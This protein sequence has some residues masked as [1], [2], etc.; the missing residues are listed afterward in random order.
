MVPYFLD[1]VI[2]FHIQLAGAPDGFNLNASTTIAADSIGT[3]PEPNLVL[4]PKNMKSRVPKDADETAMIIAVTFNPDDSIAYYVQLKSGKVFKLF[5]DKFVH[6]IDQIDPNAPPSLSILTSHSLSRL[7]RDAWDHNEEANPLTGAAMTTAKRAIEGIP[8]YMAT[9]SE[10]ACQSITCL[11][12]GGKPAMFNP[13]LKSCYCQTLAP[14]EKTFSKRNNPSQLDTIKSSA[15]REEDKSLMRSFFPIAR[16]SSETCRLM[17]SCQ[18]ESEPYFD[19]GSS[20]CLCVVYRSGVKEPVIASDTNILPRME[21][22]ASQQEED[23][24]ANSDEAALHERA[25]DSIDSQTFCSVEFARNNCYGKRVGRWNKDH[26][27]CVC[28]HL[29]DLEFSAATAD[30]PKAPDTVFPRSTGKKV[31]HIICRND[32]GLCLNPPNLYRCNKDHVLVKK[33]FN[34]QCERDC[35]CGL[36]KRSDVESREGATSAYADMDEELGKVSVDQNVFPCPLVLQTAI[37]QTPLRPRIRL[38]LAPSIAP[39]GGTCYVKRTFQ[40]AWVLHILTVAIR[41]A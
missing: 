5:G 33:R 24:V 25:P 26:T 28:V 30:T 9:F 37:L 17:I 8:S 16:P 36:L 21:R 20:Q 7:R 38:S 4:L 1:G 14:P 2:S 35:I 19:E 32:I 18:G 6:N 22:V 31:W 3:D 15:R 40:D 13:F 23:I 41:T 10:D 39:C 12:N 27:G 34:F 29:H 11:N